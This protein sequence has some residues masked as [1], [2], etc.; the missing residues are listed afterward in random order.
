[1]ANVP[2]SMHTSTSRRSPFRA[3]DPCRYGR[4]RGPNSSPAPAPAPALAAAF[5]PARA[6]APALA[7]A[8][9]P[10]PARVRRCVAARTSGRLSVSRPAYAASSPVSPSTWSQS[11]SNSSASS[12]VQSSAWLFSSSTRDSARTARPTAIAPE[13][14]RSTVSGAAPASRSASSLGLGRRGIRCSVQ[15]SPH[16]RR[17]RASGHGSSMTLT[18]PPSRWINSPL[19]DAS[20]SA[21]AMRSLR[22][23]PPCAGVGPSHAA[24]STICRVWRS[25]SGSC[26][27]S[28]SSMGSAGLP[29][30]RRTLVTGAPPAAAARAT[31]AASAHQDTNSRAALRYRVAESTARRS[32]V[33]EMAISQSTSGWRVRSQRS[34]CA[35]PASIRPSRRRCSP[36]DSRRNSRTAVP[37]PDKN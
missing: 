25:T 14:T 13:W 2:T 4:D 35:S 24:S 8:P 33:D 9:A 11:R 15:N 34:R 23:G 28:F 31:A 20:P 7:F 21:S 17:R 36:S 1:M 22:S 32:R 29:A 37:R 26:A 19:L 12:R 27:T 18:S 10:A 5:V 30:P 16:R 3:A 6:P